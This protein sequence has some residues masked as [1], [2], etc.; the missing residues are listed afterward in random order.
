MVDASVWVS[1]FLMPDA[2]HVHSQQWLESVLGE[3][4]SVYGPSL[5]LPEVAGPI[6]RVAS[7]LDA[8]RALVMIERLRVRIFPIAS[9]LAQS[10]ARIAAQFRLKGADA[11]YVA[12]ARDLGLPLVTWDDEQKMRASAVVTVRTPG[13]LMENP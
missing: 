6:S 4:N 8:R 2:N 3:R 7:E 11:V 1:R 9:D 10:A 13:E 12:L 5:L